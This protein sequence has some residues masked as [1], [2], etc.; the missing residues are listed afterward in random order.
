M[1]IQIV[2]KLKQHNVCFNALYLYPEGIDEFTKMFYI[3][4]KEDLKPPIYPFIILSSKDYKTKSKLTRKLAPWHHFIQQMKSLNDNNSN[5]DSTKYFL[6]QNGI[7]SLL[8]LIDYPESVYSADYYNNMY[9]DFEMNVLPMD[10]NYAKT[11]KK[12]KTM[13]KRLIKKKVNVLIIIEKEIYIEK[14]EQIYSEILKLRD[15]YIKSYYND[16][17]FGEKPQIAIENPKLRQKNEKDKFKTFTNLERHYLAYIKNNPVR[18][19]ELEELMIKLLDNILSDEFKQKYRRVKSS[20]PRLSELVFPDK[21]AENLL[22]D[23]GF[24]KKNVINGIS[25]YINDGNYKN[26]KETKEKLLE[27]IQKYS[28]AY[29]K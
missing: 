18:R 5:G 8:F 2:D 20:S 19:I 10:N 12:L 17:F 16:M 7:K 24:K 3:S 13:I 23:I 15:Y 14:L 11:S 27:V 4:H 21:N 29:E 25:V 1:L 22:K 28:K 6:E 26:I 9:A